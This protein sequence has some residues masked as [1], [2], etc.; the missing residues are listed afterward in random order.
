M[1]VSSGGR[2]RGRIRVDVSAR[3][4]AMDFFCLVG[5]TCIQKARTINSPW[6]R[7][8]AAKAGYV[9][10]SV[11][12]VTSYLGID[13]LASDLPTLAPNVVCTRRKRR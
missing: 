12:R 8:L 10:G 5:R 4:S 6:A 11:P 9:L 13:Y 3:F 2:R 1:T 7:A